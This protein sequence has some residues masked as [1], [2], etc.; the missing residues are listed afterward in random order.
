MGWR[1]TVATIRMQ[2]QVF[3][4]IVEVI[5]EVH[6]FSRLGQHSHLSGRRSGD[7]GHPVEPAGAALL[8]GA[9]VASTDAAGVFLLVHTQG[10]RLRPSVGATLEAESGTNDP[11]AI[12]LT[13]ML[14]EF[15]SSGESSPL[16]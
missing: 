1:S 13:L 8:V 9:V 2:L 5:A 7:G 4:W 6:D 16:H 10:L 11:F 15:I 3:A 14:V 12:F